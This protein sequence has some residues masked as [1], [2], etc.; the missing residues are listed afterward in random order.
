MVSLKTEG[1]ALTC[2]L[3]CIEGLALEVL[4]FFSLSHPTLLVWHRLVKIV[5]L[6]TNKF[7][8]CNS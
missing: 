7:L 8:E 1:R 3:P 5:L 4:R 2:K 6:N